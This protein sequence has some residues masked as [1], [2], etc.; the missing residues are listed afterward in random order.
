MKFLATTEVESDPGTWYVRGEDKEN[1]PIRYRIR[2]LP[3]DVEQ[4]LIIEGVGSRKMG[5]DESRAAFIARDMAK[6][7]KRACLAL[8][9]TE[10]LVIELGDEAAAERLGAKPGDAQVRMDGNWNDSLR[11]QFF[12]LFPG[13]QTWVAKVLNDMAALDREQEAEESKT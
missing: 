10:N 3:G 8:V 7:R 2:K 11:D 12:R 13:E 1:K 9:D 6:T 4:S 5:Q